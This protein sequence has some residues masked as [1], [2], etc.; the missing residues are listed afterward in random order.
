MTSGDLA[1]TIVTKAGGAFAVCERDG[2]V[3]AGGGHAL[4]VYRDDCR[5]LSRY[6]LRIGGARR[7]VRS[8]SDADGATGVH[9]LEGG[10]LERRIAGEGRV[11][12]R[13]RAEREVELRVAADFQ[14]ILAVRGWAPGHTEPVHVAAV[15]GGLRLSCRGRDGV[16]RATT[17]TADPPPL[18]VDAHD[19]EGALLVL[20]PGEIRLRHALEGRPVAD[21]P[22]PPPWP[23]VHSGDDRIDAVLARALR[24]VQTLRSSLDGEV[25]CAAGVPWFAT[26]FGR[27]S[28]IVA[29]QL[30]AW[31]PTLAEGTLRLLAARL[32][33]TEDPAR[34]EQPGKVLH[35]LRRG[36]AALAGPPALRTYY[37]SVDA[38]ALFGCL[39]AEH[40]SWTGDLALFRELR[41][42][43]D[44][45]LGWLGTR[46]LDYDPAPGALLANQGWKDS[47]DAI[48]GG[49][50]RPLAPP[51]T[52]VEPQGYAIRARR[53]LAALMEADGDAGRAA[54]LRADADAH[55]A[56]LDAFWLPERRCYAMAS[57]NGVVSPALASNQGHLLWGAG[58]PA[59]RARAVRDA[60]MGPALFSGWGIRTLGEGEPGYDPLSYHRGSVWPHDT[61][62]T[63][64]GLRESGF[65]EDFGVL[66]DALLD[67]AAATPD[68]RLPELFA[69]HARRPDAPPEAY[70]AACRPQAWA[71]GA[72]A[73]L[74]TA[75]L[76][77]VPDALR[78]RLG[79]RPAVLPRGAER[80]T[81]AGLRIGGAE[82]DLVARSGAPAEVTV[83]AGALDV[84]VLRPP[85]TA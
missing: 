37:G 6:D 66:L 10:R 17:V 54:A 11:E 61:A 38:T 33:R 83:R 43:V 5:H 75:A 60:V 49:D 58:L 13:L 29:H 15:P 28:L 3:P 9:V 39:L 69:G 47:P 4:G 12:E 30:L 57:G 24:D 32:G 64:T 81:V 14:D 16:T 2:S 82:V 42:A 56:M 63:A 18:R 59:G 74:L 20:A 26:L 36:E 22:A 41:P 68:R 8:A 48:V 31:D 19:P 51:I 44:A 35:E 80:I 79:L 84:E 71:A 7:A 55:A 67:A 62:I 53:G 85:G 23:R 40:A 78:G 34:E 65:D 52:L 73:G 70:P 46:L 25:Y 72:A 45:T 50:G 77:L 21:P 1:G 27:D 76:G